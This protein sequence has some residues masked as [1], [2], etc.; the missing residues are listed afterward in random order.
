[1]IKKELIKAL[2]EGDDSLEV[3]IFN[4]YTEEIT[5]HITAAGE[6]IETDP[7]APYPGTRFTIT[8][9]PDFDRGGVGFNREREE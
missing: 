3:V 8:V 2:L 1:M 6:Y 7:A 4:G 9:E 5:N